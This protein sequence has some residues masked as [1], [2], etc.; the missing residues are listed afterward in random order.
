MAL[1]SRAASAYSLTVSHTSGQVPLQKGFISCS[2]CLTIPEE[3]L[4]QIACLISHQAVIIPLRPHA[5]LK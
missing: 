2:S 3:E 5:K 4:L 1:Y